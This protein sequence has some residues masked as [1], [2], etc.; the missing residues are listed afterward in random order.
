MIK[1]NDRCNFPE[2]NGIWE[3]QAQSFGSV[4]WWHNGRRVSHSAWSSR[5]ESCLSCSFLGNKKHSKPNVDPCLKRFSK[6]IVL[7]KSYFNLD[8][9]SFTEDWLKFGNFC[10]D[11]FRR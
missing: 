3:R 10:G 4:C 7:I 1:K 2:R 6:L 11:H 9:F 5:F 8:I